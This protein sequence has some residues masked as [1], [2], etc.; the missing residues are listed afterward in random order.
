M[1][2][3]VVPMI[4]LTKHLRLL[5]IWYSTIVV[6]GNVGI[7]PDGE[8]SSASI[9]RDCARADV[10]Q[11]LP[12]RLTFHNATVWP[13]PARSMILPRPMWHL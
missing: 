7:P 13:C 6:H 1:L 4:Q 11:W 2:G 5:V 9:E 10:A 12:W 8:D 3:I